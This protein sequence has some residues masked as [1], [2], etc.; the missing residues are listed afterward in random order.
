MP[1]SVEMFEAN[2]DIDKGEHKKR[3]DKTKNQILE[4]LERSPDQAF[5]AKEIAKAIGLPFGKAVGALA[6]PAMEAYMNLKSLVGD[7]AVDKKTLGRETYYRIDR[8]SA[9]RLS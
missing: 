6:G 5:T 7:G 3:S 9:P 8:R 2:I 4:V 1:I